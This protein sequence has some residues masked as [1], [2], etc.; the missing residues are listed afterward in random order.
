VCEIHI[1]YLDINSYQDCTDFSLK[2]IK[3]MP[4]LQSSCIFVLGWNLTGMRWTRV[5]QCNTKFNWWKF[6]QSWPTRLLHILFRRSNPNFWAPPYE[7][8]TY[9]TSQRRPPMAQILMQSL[10]KDPSS[11]VEQSTPRIYVESQL[12]FHPYRPPIQHTQ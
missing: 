8:S 5:R 11:S 12:F 2:S 9:V 1:K 3:S 7:S 10:L 6:C 4:F